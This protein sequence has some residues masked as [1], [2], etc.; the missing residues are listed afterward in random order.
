MFK[1]SIFNKIEERTSINKETILNLA[2][3]IQNKN[4]K[5]EKII[6][7]LIK[8]ISSITGKN[9]TKEKEDKLVETIINDKIPKNVEKM[10]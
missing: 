9:V 1:D 8:E 6:R 3:K 2:N 4:L 7:E 10:F 5:D